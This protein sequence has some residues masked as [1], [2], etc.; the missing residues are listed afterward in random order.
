MNT[1]ENLAKDIPQVSRRATA[2][3]LS[4]DGAIAL[5]R[6]RR[7]KKDSGKKTIEEQIVIEK[8]W[9]D[10]LNKCLDSE[11]TD[12]ANSV[13]LRKKISSHETRIRRLEGGV[14]DVLKPDAPILPPLTRRVKREDRKRAKRSRI[15]KSKK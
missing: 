3:K 2:Y 9:I 13:N 14:E 7:W 4:D 8:K 15:G 11:F 5:A 10:H 1:D 12:H 6:R